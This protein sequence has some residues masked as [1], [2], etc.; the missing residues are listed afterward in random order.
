MTQTP[1]VRRFG[2]GWK[3]VQRD[4]KRHIVWE[5]I[6]VHRNRDMSTFTSGVSAHDCACGVTGEQWDAKM[7]REHEYYVQHINRRFY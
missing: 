5:C 1:G 2:N 7:R 3:A 6:H 4:E